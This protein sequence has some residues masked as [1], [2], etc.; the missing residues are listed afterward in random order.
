MQALI[1]A[2]ELSTRLAED[3]LLRPMLKVGGK[4][5]LW[6]I[7]KLYSHYG[8]NDFVVCAGYKVD[9][10]PVRFANYLWRNSVV[11]FDMDLMIDTITRFMCGIGGR[12]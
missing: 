1:L 10:I 9:R 12:K 8:L 4:L 7:M 11:T 6:H 5:M 2:E 3:A